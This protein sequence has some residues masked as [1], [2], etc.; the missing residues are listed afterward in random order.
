V[1][2][3]LRCNY[4][5]DGPGFFAGPSANFARR[6]LSATQQEIAGTAMDCS[7]P[8]QIVRTEPFE[9]WE[10]RNVEVAARVPAD[11]KVWFDGTQ[12][13]QKG[14]ER[15]FA[16]PALERGKSYA[17]EVRASW[18]TSEGAAV[19]RTHEVSVEAGKWS[20]VSFV[21][22]ARGAVPASSIERPKE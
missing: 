9:P 22:S 2:A 17:Y 15:Y 5:K 6:L 1:I 21:E 7:A 10:L 13:A 4:P 8:T 11:A 3:G 20:T 12:T 19:T 14:S 16:T 18:T